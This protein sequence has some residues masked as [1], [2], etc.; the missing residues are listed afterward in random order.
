M[1]AVNL[2]PSESRGGFA[3]VGGVGPVHALVAVLGIALLFVTIYALTTN[4]ISERKAKISRLQA[5]ANQQQ[6]AASTLSK[7]VQ[8]E[9]LAQTRAE[10]VREIASA[11]FDWHAAL[12]DLS[13]VVPA[14]TSLQSLLATVAPGATVNGPGGTASTSSGASTSTVRGYEPGPAFELKG[15]TRSH[16]DVARLMSRLR[17]INDVTR[18]TLTDSQKPDASGVGAVS[19]APSPATPGSAGCGKDRPSF[20]VVVFFKPIP[21]A[22]PTGLTSPSPGGAGAGSASGATQAA[23]TSTAPASTSTTGGTSTTSTSSPQSVSNTSSGSS[24]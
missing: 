2:I 15:C 9:K 14:N 20:D 24:K 6:V 10:T 23:S 1:R 7:Y 4:T 18:V 22:G 5:Q 8:F 3:G 17:L 11:R 16:D 19:G 13:K 21:G 12:S